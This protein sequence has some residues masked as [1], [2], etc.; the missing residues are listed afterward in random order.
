M[1]RITYFLLFFLLSKNLAHSQNQF[2]CPVSNMEIITER[3]IFETPFVE[4]PIVK[5]RS[6][7]E[8][9]FSLID[10]LV[11]NISS[12]GNRLVIAP[13]DS[14]FKIIM[15][16]FDNIKVQ[17]GDSLKAGSYLGDMIK[18][19]DKTYSLSLFYSERNKNSGLYF[20]DRLKQCRISFEHKED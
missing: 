20:F 6:D 7:Q 15:F 18:I 13:F 11:Y 8:K 9:V 19:T 2:Y 5:I 4:L 14:T 3:S 10:G 16:S 1:S 17:E 12:D